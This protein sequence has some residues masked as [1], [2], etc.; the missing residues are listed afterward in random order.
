MPMFFFHLRDQADLHEDRE[1]TDLPDLHAALDEV[2]RTNRELVGEPIGISGLE[3]E[4]ADRAGQTLLKV[5]VRPGHN[6]AASH[7]LRTSDERW[8]TSPEWCSP[9]LH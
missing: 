6:S 5:P 1:G 2:L 9:L 7:D 4:V 3:F 8:R